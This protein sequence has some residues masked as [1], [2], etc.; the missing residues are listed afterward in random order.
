MRAS[1]IERRLPR[2][3]ILTVALTITVAAGGAQRVPT[4]ASQAIVA[5]SP[6]E[7]L[8]SDFRHPSAVAVEASGAVLVA[9]HAA[10][11]LTRIGLDGRRDVLLT[12]L[13][14]PIGL[15]VGGD[16]GILILEAAARRI[17]RLDPAGTAAI[18]ASG[19]RAPRAIAASPDGRVWVAVRREQR[20]RDRDDD[21]TGNGV[22]YVISRLDDAGTLTPVVGGLV[23]IR[24][25][26]ADEEAL[27]AAI[28][29][30]VG[31]RGVQCTRLLRI[32]LLEDGTAGSP[33]PL[34][35]GVRHL[36]WGLAIDVLGGVFAGG[37]ALGDRDRDEDHD[38][39][40]DDDGGENERDR[41]HGAAGGVIRKWRGDGEAT[42]FARGLGHPLTMAMAP[43]GDLIV[44]ERRRHGRVLRFR[45]PSSPIPDVPEF[46]NQ[47]PLTIAGGAQPADLVEMF[48]SGGRGALLAEAVA[49]ADGQFTL[50]APLA[51]NEYTNLVFHATAAEG[52]G[53]TGAAAT[54][55]V[56]HDDVLPRVFSIEPAPGTHV[57]APV[58]VRARGEDDGSGVATVSFLLDDGMVA[59][60]ANPA[61][62]QPLLASAVVDTAGAAEGPQPLTTIVE[63]RAGNSRAEAQL[64]VVDRTP[65]ETLILSGPAA[66]IAERSVRFAVGGTDVWSP[67]L[68]YSWR[69]DSGA[70]SPFA[71]LA[72]V[73]LSELTPGPHRFEVRARDLAG[74]DDPTPA[75]QTF[76]IRSLRVR[77]LEPADGGTVTSSSIWI[78]GTVEGAVGEV[79]VRLV[80][81]S[82]FDGTLAAPVE[83]NSFAMEVPADSA[84]V[85]LAVIAADSSGGTAQASVSVIISP[86]G[87]FAESLELWPPGGIAP[88]SVRIGLHGVSDLPIAIDLEGDG[89]DEFT[90]VAAADD[91][92][93]AYTRPGS[94]VPNLRITVP[95]GSLLV[96]R[97]LVEVYD[98][99]ALDAH[100]QA[101]W[102]GFKDALRNND[103]AAA[104][105]FIVA[106]RREAW[107]EYFRALPADVAGDVDTL[108]P[109]ITFVDAGARGAQYEMLVQQDGVTFS[110]AVWFQVD[111]DGRWR[112][113]RF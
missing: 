98:R 101:V 51:L 58:L 61:P 59:S 88:L 97:G 21:R 46:T 89:T 9:D 53:L 73:E 63:D 32:P 37:V 105:A 5:L 104:A 106:E 30:T 76:T 16:G 4:A 102:S 110:Y 91:F 93:A 42:I 17:V 43:T 92:Q 68:E 10:G 8:A 57:R 74:N 75:V 3:V 47:S 15:A 48:G 90:G 85:P 52:L 41:D 64:L 28:A 38:R 99:V 27:Y 23:G 31:E 18:V 60:I 11:T 82:G 84:L 113:W 62:P 39:D 80:L 50:L 20:R 109:A 33:Q 12:D 7:V 70:W 1:S 25:L 26:A 55:T 54:A 72:V 108:F 83:G 14:R 24:G 87:T 71:P 36:S 77:I 95:D 100:L 35:H 13:R 112:L 103:A 96:R 6:V 67:V 107:A 111:A 44:A 45:A 81:P 86:D 22:E 40:D 34:S 65:P 49:G 94:Y 2:A 19:L 29:R 69:F 56:L 79:T 78:R 66:E